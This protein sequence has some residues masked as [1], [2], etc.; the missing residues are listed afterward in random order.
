MS[1]GTL[2][3]SVNRE[4]QKFCAALGTAF[5]S[6]EC[7]VDRTVAFGTP[8]P[9]FSGIHIGHFSNRCLAR[10]AF[11]FQRNEGNFLRLDI[12]RIEER[13]NIFV[14]DLDFSICQIF[15]SCKGVIDLGFTLCRNAK[16]TD[17]LA[18]STS[19]GKLAENHTIA[20]PADIFRGHDFVGFAMFDHAVLMNSG[21]MR[22]S[23]GTDNRFVRLDRETGHRRNKFRS[24]NQLT[25]VDVDT[26]LKEVISGLNRHDDFF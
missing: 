18:E 25:R 13:L 2:G 26:E 8:H 5:N 21:R 20:C 15:E 3:Q 24:R 12:L 9:L 10:L 17:T 22:E 16:L 11:L 19:S 6:L 1:F 14:K 4:E 23:I 7:C